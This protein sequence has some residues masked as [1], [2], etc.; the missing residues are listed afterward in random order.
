VRRQETRFIKRYESF[1]Y[2]L[3]GVVYLCFL[4]E[5]EGCGF[6]AAAVTIAFA[7]G[8][9]VAVAGAALTVAEG[10]LPPG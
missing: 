7:L 5:A 3:A 8:T 2:R 4:A 1:T 9:G 10:V 6:G